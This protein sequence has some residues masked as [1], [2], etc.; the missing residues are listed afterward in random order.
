MRNLATML[1]V[2]LI[3]LAGPAAAQDGESDLEA[4]FRL[5]KMYMSANMLASEV[6]IIQILNETF[7][8]A[9]VT[10]EAYEAGEVTDDD[11]AGA[12]IYLS[13]AIWRLQFLVLPVCEAGLEPD[14]FDEPSIMP[15][16]E[17][18]QALMGELL[19]DVDTFMESD[20]FGALAD[21]VDA[22]READ[23]AGRLY[24]LADHAQAAAG[25]EDE[26]VEADSGDMQ[27]ATPVDGPEG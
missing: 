26:P 15:Y 21:F 25:V 4:G 18:A 9:R 17:N 2:L 3:C 5:G 27:P 10:D 11:V 13:Y 20:G 19:A 14:A 16:K 23:Y 7:D 12:Q 1:I 8:V 6:E 24:E 22:T